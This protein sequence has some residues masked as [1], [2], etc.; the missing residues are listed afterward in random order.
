M[1]F[2]FF[3]AIVK[4][5]IMLFILIGMV[6]LLVGMKHYMNRAQRTG[7]MDDSDN[8]RFRRLIDADSGVISRYNLFSR[9]LVDSDH[10]G[11]RIP[12]VPRFF[13]GEGKKKNRLSSGAEMM[14][15][16]K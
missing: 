15:S 11:D 12:T 7:E 13:Q 8:D 5:L 6:L 2:Q 9:F 16:R 4:I 3:M 14:R 10:D 1:I